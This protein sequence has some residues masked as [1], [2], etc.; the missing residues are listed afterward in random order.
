MTA[1]ST[2]CGATMPAPNMRS[3]ATSQK[4][5]IQSLYARAMAVAYAGSRPSVP[6]CS[7]LSSPRTNR[8]RDG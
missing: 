8:P 2:S 7:T 5:F 3:G 6:I 1:P 4:S